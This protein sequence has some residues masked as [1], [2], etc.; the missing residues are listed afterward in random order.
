MK[1]NGYQKVIE[2]DQKLIEIEDNGNQNVIEIESYLK[3]N[4]N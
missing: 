3:S 4:S 2:C 1:Y